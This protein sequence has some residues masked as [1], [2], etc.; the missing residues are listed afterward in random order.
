MRVLSPSLTQ[1][2][3]VG[4]RYPRNDRGMTMVLPDV[5]RRGRSSRRAM[6]KWNSRMTM[7][8]P[9]LFPRVS[10]RILL[11]FFHRYWIHVGAIPQT[12]QQVSARLLCTNLPQEVT[13]DVLSVLFQQCVPSLHPPFLSQPFL[14][15]DTGG[16]NQS[17]SSYLQLPTL[18]A[19]R[20]KWLKSCTRRLNWPQW[21]R[22]I[23]MGLL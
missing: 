8:T 21:P 12:T 18:P 19:S 6:R 20:S 7:M 4:Y 13:D 14:G 3:R 23:W 2:S 10:S 9:P 15:S 22:K 17:E 11:G 1:S 5:R 16:Y